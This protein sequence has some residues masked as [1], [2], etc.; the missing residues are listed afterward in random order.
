[1]LHILCIASL[2]FYIS[3]VSPLSEMLETPARLPIIGGSMYD[4]TFLWGLDN[5]IHPFDSM[6]YGRVERCLKKY[7]SQR[8]IEPQFHIP[9]EVTYEQLALVHDPAYIEL[10]NTDKTAISRIVEIYLLRFLPRFLIDI[11][12]LKPMRRATGGT[13]QAARL[14]VRHGWAFNLGGGYHHAKERE[15]EEGGY[16]IYADIPLAVKTLWREEDS[17]LK[18]MIVDLDAHQGNGH[19]AILG[20]DPRISIFD[21][22][23]CRTYPMDEAAKRCITF[24]VPI[25]PGTSDDIYIPLLKRKLKAALDTLEVQGRKPDLIIYNAGT[26]ILAGDPEGELGV[27]AEGII[28]RDAIVFAEAK[29]RKIRILYLFSGG[30]TKGSWFNRKSGSA[31]VIGKSLKNVLTNIIGIGAPGVVDVPTFF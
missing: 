22:Y 4:S 15:L 6:K 18:V 23:N 16:C 21:M 8:G 2:V 24:D 20:G 17:Q 30:Y 10:I 31:Y 3:F 19:E 14:A 12:L 5:F 7:F 13:V 1:M 29:E 26:D 9:V 27:S 28:Q 11:I 25:E